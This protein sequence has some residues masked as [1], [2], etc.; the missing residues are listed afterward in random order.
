MLTVVVS[1]VVLA[2]VFDYIN[3]MHDSANAIAT[4]VSTRVLSPRQAI[5]MAATLNFVG[6]LISVSVAKTIGKDIVDPAHVTVLTVL[7][8]VLAAILWNLFTWWKGI[9]SSSSHALIGGI[10]GAAV[11]TSG[12]T[13]LKWEGIRKVVS[14]LVFSPII[15]LGLGFLVMLA[16][17]W[18]CRRMLPGRVN[19]FFKR[20]QLASA[21]LMAFSHGGND[22]QKSM[23]VIAMALVAGGFQSKLDIPL[24][25]KLACA[26]A[27]AFGTAAGGW[28]II[29]TMGSKLIDLQPVHGFAAET[30]AATV[31][32][33]ATHW[34]VPIST[35]HAISGSIMGVGTTRSLKAVKWGVVGQMV[36]A[37]VLTIP[38]T[39]LLAYG[40]ES[41][42]VRF[43]HL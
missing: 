32:L 26:C 22:A 17:L 43:V 6:A 4:V 31:I 9:P 37:W 7:A 42:L 18:I 20:A 2:L 19:K 29:K 34:G 38:A 3:G 14:G 40:F 30:A 12:W 13:H 36:T 25:V 5:M 11:A 1:L 39:A 21:A 10:V 8:A 16:I 27:M 15:G 23:G 28:R 24:W 41:L 35:T 33:T